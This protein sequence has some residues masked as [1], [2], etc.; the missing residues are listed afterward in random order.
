MNNK[1][2][3]FTARD[4]LRDFCAAAL[5]FG[6]RSRAARLTRPVCA[7]ELECEQ[8]TGFKSVR[9]ARKVQVRQP[10]LAEGGAITQQLGKGGPLPLLFQLPSNPLVSSPLSFPNRR[11]VLSALHFHTCYDVMRVQK[12]VKFFFNDV[13]QAAAPLPNLTL[14]CTLQTRAR[15]RLT[16]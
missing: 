2:L 5:G 16:F 15:R 10:V 1:H 6:G 3:I 7:R 12:T 8:Q 4:I 11:P 14:L 13:V 9:E